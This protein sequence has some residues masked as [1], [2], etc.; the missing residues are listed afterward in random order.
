M[1]EYDYTFMMDEKEETWA[2]AEEELG[3]PSIKP[4]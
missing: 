3:Q 4:V 2:D 1:G